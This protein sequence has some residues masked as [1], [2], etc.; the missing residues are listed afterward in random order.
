MISKSMRRRLDKERKK[1]STKK[2]SD[3][4]DLPSHFLP[5]DKLIT[6]TLCREKSA[7]EKCLSCEKDRSKYTLSNR[8]KIRTFTTLCF[9]L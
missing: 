2:L 8:P 5:L 4:L 9:S 7:P 6:K 3:L 1:E